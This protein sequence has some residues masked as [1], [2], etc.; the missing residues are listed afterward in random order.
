MVRWLGLFCLELISHLWMKMFLGP[1]LW[2]MYFAAYWL[3]ANIFLCSWRLIGIRETAA[4]K[5]VV[6]RLHPYKLYTKSIC[7][8]FSQLQ[9]FGFASSWRLI[10]FTETAAYKNVVLRFAPIQTTLLKIFKGTPD[11][12]P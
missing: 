7:I 12:F 11:D 5:N 3:C 6:L 4:Y 8:C 2:Y 10:G 9:V 1:L